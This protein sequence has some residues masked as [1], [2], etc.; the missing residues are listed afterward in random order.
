MPQFDPGQVKTAVAPITV[1]PAGLNCETE[2]YLVSDSTKVATA[3][4]KSFISTGA[5]Q[6]IS[7][8]LTMPAPGTYPV[9]LDV[10]AQGML[11]GAYKATE[12][13]I[14]VGVPGVE[15][16]KGYIRMEYPSVSEAYSGWIGFSPAGQELNLALF[17][18][19]VQ[20]GVLLRNPTQYPLKYTC[21]LYN[22]HWV[23]LPPPEYQA[24]VT[25]YLT[26]PSVEPVKFTGPAGQGNPPTGLPYS[27]YQY[28]CDMFLPPGGELPPGKTG[29]VYTALYSQ[30]RRWNYVY[31]EIKGNGYA[32]GKTL[33]FSGWYSY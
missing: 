21:T 15:I 13:V 30:S 18:G 2:L 3:G 24:Y 28:E 9:Y 33:L 16:V 14:I 25:D 6:D 1:K 4:I 31:I 26:L 8:P 17:G 19:R 11:I 10:A 20:A 12:D 32:L 22:Y 7:F 23:E 29:F 5:K 27:G